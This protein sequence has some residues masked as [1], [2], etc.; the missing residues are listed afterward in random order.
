MAG[1]HEYILNALRDR[2]KPSDFSEAV[3]KFYHQWFVKAGESYYVLFRRNLRITNLQFAELISL[4]RCHIVSKDDASFG[5]PLFVS[6]DEFKGFLAEFLSDTLPILPEGAEYDVDHIA[7]LTREY[8]GLVKRVVVLNPYFGSCTIYLPPGLAL[9]A[10]SLCAES[11]Y[12][13]SLGRLVYVRNMTKATQEE[14][15]ANIEEH[16]D[17]Y[18]PD[19]PTIPALFRVYSHED[20]TRWDR[21]VVTDALEDEEWGTLTYASD[22]SYGLDDVKIQTRKAYFRRDNII[23]V[24]KALKDKFESRLEIPAPGSFKKTLE[25]FRE[26]FGRGPERT[27]FLLNDAGITPKGAHPDAKKYYVCY[28]Q[29]WYNNDPFYTFDEDKPAWMSHTTIPHSMAAAMIN[30]TRP[31]R[32]DRIRLIDPF[33]GSG[34]ML[35]EALKRTEIVPISGDIQALANLAATDNLEFFTRTLPDVKKLRDTLKPYLVRETLMAALAPT[36]KGYSGTHRD[37]AVARGEFESAD[38]SSESDTELGLSRSKEVAGLTYDQRI[39]FYLLLRTRLRHL[40]EFSEGRSHWS[41]AFIQELRNVVL[42][43]NSHIAFLELAQDHGTTENGTPFA[44]GDYSRVCWLNLNKT[45]A[46]AS[47]VIFLRDATQLERDEYDLIITDPPYGFNKREED[48]ELIKLYREFIWGAVAALRNEGQLVICCPHHSYSGRHVPVFI[49]PEFVTQQ[50]LL[51]ARDN[52]KGVRTEQYSL[53][54]EL[55]GLRPPYYWE[56]P[57]ALQRS[58]LHFRFTAD[59][60]AN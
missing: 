24:L 52:R 7:P 5:D 51:A 36:I 11:G 37:F 21:S 18:P 22:L 4:L 40:A 25:D 1:F 20:F 13:H 31:W 50:V 49:Q 48:I 46:A 32:K 55:D 33:G 27:F 42:R 15:L 56:A 58:I 57:T 26:K 39:L 9:R 17:K 38:E 59:A 2:D 54:S 8:E 41:S 6:A 34:T 19:N 3:A 16:L 45:Q 43:L 14:L 47:E 35:L 23:A 12:I 44:I 60:P 28:E 10:D 53:P 30:I 29:M